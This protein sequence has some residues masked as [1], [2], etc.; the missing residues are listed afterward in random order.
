MFLQRK[1]TQRRTYL[2]VATCLIG[3]LL[4]AMLPSM[5][6]ANDDDDGEDERWERVT[7]SGSHQEQQF[8]AGERVEVNNATVDDDIFAAG[9]DLDFDTVVAEMIVAA[10]A[11]L[12]FKDINADDLI[13]AAGAS[14]RFEDVEAEELI[15]AGGELSFSGQV[16]D[17]IVA[18]TCPFCPIHGRLRLKERAQIGDDARLAGRE[19]VVDGR[20]DGNLY[21]AGQRVELS[22]KV[23]GDAAIEA[24]RIV[25]GSGA[26]I[27]GDLRY[28]SPNELEI[29]DGASVAGEIIQVEPRIPFDREGPEHPVWIAVLVMLGF[30]LALLVLGVALQLAI[31][32]ILIG[33]TEAVSKGPW[34]C[35][36]RGLVLAL[37]APAVA[38]LLMFTV[39]GTPIGILIFAALVLLYAMAFV[40][41]SYSIGLYV[42]RLFGKSETATGTGSRI[43]WTCVGILLLVIIGMIPLIGWAFGMLAIICGLG[44]VISQLGPLFRRT[45]SMPAPG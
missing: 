13:L 44:A 37:L 3:V 38:A 16:E 39:I 14:L 17:D 35:L 20:V 15:L 25:L 27:A 8:L 9:N 45:G 28:A 7:L 41:I 12:R 31:P 29:R 10:G 11:S 6:G 5:T 22:G 43:L 36:G 33:S 21:A 42:S 40:A 24:E 32:G 23:G 19:V 18:A 1:E 26:R 34:A 4:L 2:A 30:F